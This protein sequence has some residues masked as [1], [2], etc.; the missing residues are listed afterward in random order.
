[1]KKR[2]FSV[3]LILAMILSLVPAASAAQSALFTEFLTTGKLDAPQAC[4]ITVRATPST[5]GSWS[6]R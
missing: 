5:C 6:R 3:L 4:T 2:L 1:M